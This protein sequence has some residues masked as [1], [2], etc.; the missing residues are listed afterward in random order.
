[1]SPRRLIAAVA[2]IATVLM[3]QAGLVSALTAPLLVSL[4]AVFVA[5]V[6][7]N[8]G[9]TVGM[10]IGFT[11]GLFADLGSEHPAGVLALCWLALG[12]GCG[13][14]AESA[15]SVRLQLLLITLAAGAA[16]GL[17]GALLSVLKS[18][19]VDLA[20]VVRLSA[21]TTALDAMLALLIYG[22]VRTVLRADGLRAPG[23]SAAFGASSRRARRGA[24]SRFRRRVA[25][26]AG[27]QV[28]PDG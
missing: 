1:M 5:V 3:V 7:V 9:P 28:A 6:G 26:A 20:T 14:L 13:V 21:P 19:G 17:A 10:T 27:R 24:S 15:Y 23:W 25:P 18:P 11:T 22:P 2:A 8:A 4:P 12:L 16:S